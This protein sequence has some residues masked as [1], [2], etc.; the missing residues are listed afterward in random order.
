[1][2]QQRK[3]SIGN[4][5][6]FRA[7]TRFLVA[8]ISGCFVS[9][10]IADPASF[11]VV[12]GTAVAVQ[13][14]KVLTITNSAGAILNWNKFGVAVGDTTHFQQTSASSAVLNRV[15]AGAP[16]GK[17]HDFMPREMSDP[18]AKNLL[19]D[20]VTGLPTIPVIVDAL[21]EKLTGGA[22]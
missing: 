15:L 16:G 20:G 13:A 9:G 18:R 21:R 6:P 14:G 1:M 5:R 22:E 3:S 19:F 8:A 4:R 12:N 7:Q 17:Y 11:T 10:A 2:T